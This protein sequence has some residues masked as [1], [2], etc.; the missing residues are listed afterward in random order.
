MSD[1]PS[2]SDAAQRQL[3]AYNARNI[4]AF[5]AAYAPGCVVRA[6]PSGDVLLEGREAMRAQ[7]GRQFAKCTALHAVLLARVEHEC[8]VIDHEEVTGLHPE[9]VVHAVAMY[10]VREGLIQNVWFLKEPT[11]E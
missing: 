9:R 6:F 4:D 1:L 3:D 11:V 8:F 10:E 7:Y 2:P 5:V